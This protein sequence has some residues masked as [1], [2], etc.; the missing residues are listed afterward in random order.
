MFIPVNRI[1]RRRAIAVLRLTAPS[2]D[3]VSALATISVA[4]V[5]PSGQGHQGRGCLQRWSSGDVVA[6]P[7]NVLCQDNPQSGSAAS[8]R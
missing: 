8:E 7:L 1:L 3:P 2:V 4:N 5:V 6:C